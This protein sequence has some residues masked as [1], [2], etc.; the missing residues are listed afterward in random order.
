MRLP[1]SAAA[2]YCFSFKIKA[3]DSKSEL[4]A[5]GDVCLN[6]GY[7]NSYLLHGISLTNGYAAVVFGFKVVGYAERSSDFVLAAIS[8]TDRACF[9]KLNGKFLCKL[10]VKLK[11]LFGELL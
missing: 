4:E 11:R 5:L 6:L 9:I 7:G 2:Q 10:V 1:Y 8:L 3:A